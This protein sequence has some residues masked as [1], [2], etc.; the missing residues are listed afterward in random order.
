VT[1]LPQRS[2]AAGELGPSLYAR[3][4]LARYQ[5]GLRTCRNFIV[6]RDGGITNRPGTAYVGLC[7]ATTTRLLP[8]THDDTGSVLEVSDA[9]I[10]I[11]TAGAYTGVTIVSP[12]AAAALFEI[13][14]SQHQ[15]V[16]TL[17]HPDYPVYE[18]TRTSAAVWTMLP[19]T[20]GPGIDPPA[21]LTTTDSFPG[22][23]FICWAVTAIAERGVEG[24]RVRSGWHP[25]DA[26]FP[27][28]AHA[29]DADVGCRHRSARVQRL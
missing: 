18:L 16:L 28:I 1:N 13:Q 17:T 6:L 5:A 14:Y 11:V 7:P 25:G 3:T 12:Y 19:V 9:E 4:D 2:F 8:F 26:A 10:R 15:N 20:F 22:T 23:N 21:N 27:A 24:V 29:S